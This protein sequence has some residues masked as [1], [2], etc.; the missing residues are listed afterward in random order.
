MKA[1]ALVFLALLAGLA[2]PARAADLQVAGGILL[3]ANGVS[4]NGALY[5][6]KFLDGTCVGLFAGCDSAADFTF[7]APAD[8]AAA[9]RALLD[10]VL[11][12]GVQG[13]FDSNPAL[14]NG[15]TGNQ[16]GF[17]LVFTPADTLVNS[18]VAQNSTAEPFDLVKVAFTLPAEDVSIYATVVYAVWTPH[19]PA[20]PEPPV[21]FLLLGGAAALGLR[22]VALSRR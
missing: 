9:S 21:A 1:T 5:D 19:A 11:I 10:Q 7:G 14:T 20:V 18:S 6:V 16:E 15:C 8:F 13:S 12:D 17:C 3:G 22:R 4:V 2:A